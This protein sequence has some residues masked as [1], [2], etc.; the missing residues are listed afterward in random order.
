M[1]YPTGAAI[2]YDPIHRWYVVAGQ[3]GYLGGYSLK[4]FDL[5]GN[6]LWGRTQDIVEVQDHRHDVIHDFLIDTLRRQIVITGETRYYN[7]EKRALWIAFADL[8][9]RI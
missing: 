3:I 7:A 1:F 2:R 9:G 6:E 8:Q 5:Q 4:A